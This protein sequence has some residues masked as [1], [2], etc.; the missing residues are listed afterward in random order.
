MSFISWK[1]FDQWC[2]WAKT[3]CVFHVEAFLESIWCLFMKLV[4]VRAIWE[5]E[6]PLWRMRYYVKWPLFD[7]KI[8]F[9][10]FSQK[11]HD[12]FI[13]TF[14]NLTKKLYLQQVFV[15]L[16]SKV[17]VSSKVRMLLIQLFLGHC[18]P[19]LVYYRH[20][21]TFFMT[22]I[23]Y[24]KL[25]RLSVCQFVCLR[26]EKIIHSEYCPSPAPLRGRRVGK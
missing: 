24:K 22:D 12:L 1:I 6:D 25:Q 10:N 23:Y 3:S 19:S 14:V 26:L 5:G 20:L 11:M 7:Q 21:K 15:L 4:W 18:P 2:K 16:P 9:F 8:L 13:F 17:C